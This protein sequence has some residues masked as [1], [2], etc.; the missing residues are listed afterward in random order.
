METKYRD[1]YEILGLKR[2]ASEKEIRDTYR[3]LARKYHPDINPGDKKAEEKFKEI[4]EAYEVLRDPEKKAK[5]DRLGTNWQAGADFRPPPGWEGVHVRMDDFRDFAGLRG[6]DFSDFFSSLFGQR[7]GGGFSQK[8]PHRGRKTRGEDVDADLKITLEE[9]YRG[10][11]RSITIQKRE[12]CSDCEGKGVVNRS[13][14][15]TCSGMGTILKPRRL[16]IKIPA[17]V[18]DGSRI[19]LARQGEEG[20]GG[21]RAGD[22]YLHIKLE[23][24]PHF[25]VIDHDVQIELPLMSWEAILGTE[26]EVLTLKGYVKMKIPPGIQSGQRLRLRGLGLSGKGGKKG[27]QYVKT[28]II[29]PK[30]ISDREKDLYRELAQL[31]EEKISEVTFGDVRR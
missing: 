16:D 13:S 31:N 12:R 14:C 29:V 27:D 7:P 21:G 15:S 6:G 20:I 26:V 22:M 2:D 3:R 30:T 9:A 5:Y 25:T 19:R 8:T 17:G 11:R 18:K 24:H 4:N 28:K 1:Y 10:G 23:P